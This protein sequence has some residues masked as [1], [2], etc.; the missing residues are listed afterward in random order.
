[1][2]TASGVGRRDS[3][4]LTMNYELYPPSQKT[5][6]DLP[7][8]E[9]D[10]LCY[11]RMSP[12]LNLQADNPSVATIYRGEGGYIKNDTTALAVG[13][14][15]KNLTFVIARIPIKSGDVS[16]PV[17]RLLLPTSRDRNDKKMNSGQTLIEAVIAFTVLVIIITAIATL[18]ISSISNSIYLRNQDNANKY[19]QEGMDFLTTKKK[20]NFSS[21]V[22]GNYCLIYNSNRIPQWPLT[23]GSGSTCNSAYTSFRH[24]I[25]IASG[26]CS[27]AGVSG[28]KIIM[29]VSW[30]DGKCIGG[31]YCHRS[32]M[33]TCFTDSNIINPNPVGP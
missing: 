6:F 33:Q 31:V 26:G 21:I 3:K 23:S 17:L 4:L 24:E 20:E 30:T 27:A 5:I 32:N 16:I 13:L 7:V 25:N 15:V 10:V 2:P 9:C 19:A 14:S 28:I 29:T 22:N 1:M 18:T 11:G 12:F 8:D